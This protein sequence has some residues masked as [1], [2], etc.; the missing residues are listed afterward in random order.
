MNERRLMRIAITPELLVQA[1]LA[2]GEKGL[3]RIE[4]A[5]H[6]TEVV[7][8]GYDVETDCLYALLRH[9]SFNEVREGEVI[10][11]M[12]VIPPAKEKP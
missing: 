10:P 4:G 12:L 6:D 7:S 5:P 1:L 3:Y 11:R 9:E 8:F 2:S